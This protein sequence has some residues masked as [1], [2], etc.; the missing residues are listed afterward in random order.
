MLHFRAQQHH[1]RGDVGALDVRGIQ[2]VRD[3]DPQRVRDD[4]PHRVRDD[5][6]HVPQRVRDDDPQRVRD[7]VPRVL[8][9]VR[10]DDPRVREHHLVRSERDFSDF[11]SNCVVPH[12]RLHAH[13][14]DRPYDQ[15]RDGIHGENDVSE[16]Y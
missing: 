6:P 15:H 10:D 16:T 11:H 13:D 9:H 7:D 8:Q 5:V 1:S 3:D 12:V 2:R 14:D 4:D